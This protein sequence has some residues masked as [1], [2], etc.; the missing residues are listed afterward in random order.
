MSGIVAGILSEKLK[1]QIGTFW[2]GISMDSP[3]RAKLE[4]H[5][6]NSYRYH[7]IRWGTIGGSERFGINRIDFKYTVGAY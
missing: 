5:M 4:T 1:T 2:V 3:S 6:D 7:Q